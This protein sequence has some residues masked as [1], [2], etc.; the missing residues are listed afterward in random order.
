[1]GGAR[2]RS[3]ARGGATRPC[4]R[5]AGAARLATRQR[6]ERSEKREADRLGDTRVMRPP[7]GAHKA[8]AAHTAELDPSPATTVCGSDAT[9]AAIDELCW[10]GAGSNVFGRIRAPSERIL[11]RTDSLAIAE[12]RANCVRPTA[13]ESVGSASSARPFEADVGRAISI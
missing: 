12:R 13:S 3:G 7:N 4:A 6:E 11:W 10:A 9:V 1:M 2:V 5:R 8:S